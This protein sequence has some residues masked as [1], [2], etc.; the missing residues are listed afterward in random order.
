M[1]APVRLL[2]RDARIRRWV[3]HPLGS[4]GVKGPFP[5]FCGTHYDDVWSD[6]WWTVEVSKC[7][8]MGSNVWSWNA[9]SGAVLCSDV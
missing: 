8:V 6:V 7:V 9:R 1:D 2:R 4:G 3:L 5:V